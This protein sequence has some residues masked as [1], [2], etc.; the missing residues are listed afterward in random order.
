MNKDL[1]NKLVAKY[2]R[3]FDVN[4]NIQRTL[5]PFGF[6]HDDGW[7]GL[8]ERLCEKLKPLAG[9]S[10]EVLQ[11]KEKFGGLRFYVIHS[12]AEMDRI[13]A[14]AENESFTICEVCGAPGKCM[15]RGYWLQTLC[16]GH[17]DELGFTPYNSTR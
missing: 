17:A 10:F 4:G 1:E 11:V 5:M 2:P 16:P 8:L 13:I 9:D 7:Y 15:V 3:W 12:T 6:D 14:D